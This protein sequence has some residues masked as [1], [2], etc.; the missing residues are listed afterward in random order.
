MPEI[1]IVRKQPNSMGEIRI[2][3]FPTP[4][5]K[6]CLNCPLPAK[7]CNGNCKRYKEELKKLKEKSKENKKSE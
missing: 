2:E 3:F 6:I 7:K 4:E 1:D 5:Q